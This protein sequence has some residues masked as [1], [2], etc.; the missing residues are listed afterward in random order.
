MGGMVRRPKG[1]SLIEVM[2]LTV[3]IGLAVVGL[4]TSFVM[5]RI[6]TGLTRHKVQAVNLL[7]A[8]ME[9]LKSKGY[10]YLNALYPNPAVERGLVLDV[11]EDELSPADDLTWSRATRI[12]DN[13]G[14]GVLEITVTVVW[15][16]RVASGDRSFSESLF[17]LVAPQK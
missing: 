15:D 10:D 17:T 2:V 8:K 16:E 1:F 12:S 5:G 6:H 7:R 13:D 3:V 14:D 4:L 11:G 9:E